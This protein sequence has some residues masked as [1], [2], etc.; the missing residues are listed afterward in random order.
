MKALK[1]LDKFKF[2]ICIRHSCL[3]FGQNKGKFFT[4]VSGLIFIRVLLRQIGHMT[5][6]VLI[7]NFTEGFVVQDKLCLSK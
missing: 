4:I 5:H 7:I 3:H 1:V 6:S 2:L